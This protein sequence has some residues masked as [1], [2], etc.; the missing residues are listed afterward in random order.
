MAPPPK[1]RLVESADEGTGLE[2][3]MLVPQSL[4]LSLLALC[5]EGSDGSDG[6][7]IGRWRAREAPRLLC[8]IGAWKETL[9]VWSMISIDREKTRRPCLEP[10]NYPFRKVFIRSPFKIHTY[11]ILRPVESTRV[12]LFFRFRKVVGYPISPF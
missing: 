11:K 8:C 12:T 7:E 10:V 6:S 9:L 2:S 3:K 1:L 5:R 4:R